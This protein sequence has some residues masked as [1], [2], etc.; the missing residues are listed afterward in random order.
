MDDFL[1]FLWADLFMDVGCLESF[2]PNQQVGRNIHQAF[3]EFL[4]VGIETT[5]RVAGFK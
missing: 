1:V 4:S 5:D 2:H 3:C